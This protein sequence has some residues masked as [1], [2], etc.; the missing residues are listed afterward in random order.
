MSETVYEQIAK[1]KIV[2]IVRG[3]YGED[4][5]RLAEALY[6]GGIRLLEVAFEPGKAAETQEA[7]RQIAAAMGGRM[8]VGAG[9]VSDLATLQ[10]AMDAGAEF[11]ISPNT[12]AAVIRSTK[13]AGLVSIPG[14]MTP[15]EIFAAYQ[16]GADFVKV[17]PAANL[18]PAYI[19]AV[20]SPFP[21]IPLMAVG[22][23]DENNMAEFLKVGVAGFGIGG[24]LV[25]KAWIREGA[26]E[27]ITAVAAAMCEKVK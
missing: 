23:V 15:T 24:N 6:A 27:K 16:S 22:G 5:L 19:K 13:E 11:I 4:C 18:G 1:E 9:T 12:D 26:F 7:I 10:L 8:H 14:A 17:F 25:N 3:V 21:H 2:A 20:R